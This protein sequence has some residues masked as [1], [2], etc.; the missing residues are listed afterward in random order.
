MGL[1]RFKEEQPIPRHEDPLRWR[2]SFS[3]SSPRMDNLAR[4][5]CT[6]YLSCPATSVPSESW[7]TG[8]PE[9]SSNW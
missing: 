5:Y 8:I 4:W 1:R 9:T 3:Q 2:Q 7:R 6:L